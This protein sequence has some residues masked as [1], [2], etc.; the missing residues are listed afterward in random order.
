[1]T[2]RRCPICQ[3]PIS[4]LSQNFYCSP[5]CEEQAHVE[6]VAW[7]YVLGLAPF[8]SVEFVALLQDALL[9]DWAREMVWQQRALEFMVC[10]D[11][12]FASQELRRYVLQPAVPIFVLRQLTPIWYDILWDYEEIPLRLNTRNPDSLKKI[13]D[14]WLLEVATEHLSSDIRRVA[15]RNPLL[16]LPLLEKLAYDIYP[17][18]RV[19]VVLNPNVPEHL[20]L[21]LAD[22]PAQN[23]GEAVAAHPQTPPK[24]LVKLMLRNEPLVQQALQGRLQ[25]LSKPQNVDSVVEGLNESQL[26]LD[27]LRRCLQHQTNIVKSVV[28][29]PAL[30]LDILKMLR[31]HNDPAI[32]ELVQRQLTKR[33]SGIEKR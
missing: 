3:N 19:G 5:A 10:E 23:V 20:L 25:V 13:T 26:G 33:K 9:R 7:R 16:P 8:S 18:V 2:T 17:L 32:Q 24:G 29:H 1:M 21:Y 11:Y 27:D 28:E 15:A 31:Q 22:D 6:Q 12:T 4:T 14:E 30:A